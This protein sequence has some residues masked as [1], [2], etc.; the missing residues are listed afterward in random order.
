ML[1]PNAPETQEPQTPDAEEPEDEVTWSPAP[2]VL[3]AASHVAALASQLAQR[4]AEEAGRLLRTAAELIDPA[5]T[6][7][8]KIGRVL[9]SPAAPKLVEQLG[10]LSHSILERYAEANRPGAWTDCFP[11]G[12]QGSIR[13]VPVPQYIPPYRAGRIR[14]FDDYDTALAA[15]ARSRFHV[16]GAGNAR[17]VER[18]RS[19]LEAA[20]DAFDAAINAFIA[21]KGE[22]GGLPANVP[23]ELVVAVSELR[24]AV[25][26]ALL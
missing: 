11:C 25:G 10:E 8:D 4:D 6:L 5:P 23:P 21:S 16:D 19:D 1:E 26:K 20:T 24:Q 22:G 18:T 14:Q 9:D 12:T 7:W 15:A 13:G 2:E 3:L 17:D